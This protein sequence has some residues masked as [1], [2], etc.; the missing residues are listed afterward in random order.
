MN[1]LRA[2]KKACFLLTLLFTAAFCLAAYTCSSAP[3][4]R[5][6][7]PVLPA[8]PTEPEPAPAPKPERNVR[9]GIGE[10]LFNSPVKGFTY[11]I[12]YDLMD[13][14]NVGSYRSW[15]SHT[16]FINYSADVSVQD[17]GRLNDGLIQL[18]NATF[19]T[20][21]KRGV[22]EIIGHGIMY[23]RVASTVSKSERT[24]PVRN[25][26]PGSE[27]IRFLEKTEECY[28][29]LSKA[30]TVID[31]WE[32]G[33]ESNSSTF[34]Q[35]PSGVFTQSE[36][37]AIVTDIMYYANKGIRRGNPA[38]V[39]INP[40]FSPYKGPADGAGLLDIADYL[41][42]M[43][44]NIKSGDFPAGTVKSTDSSDYFGGLAWHPYYYHD[45]A[46]DEDWK[47]YNDAIFRVAENNGD[48]DLKVWF[49]EVGFTYYRDDPDEMAELLENQAGYIT[50]MFALIDDMPYVRTVN[51]FRLFNC[52][53][54][55]GWMLAEEFF[56]LFCEPEGGAGFV[57]NAKAYALQKV[58]GG[59]GDL[60][61]HG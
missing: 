16:A 6:Q 21:K 22:K 54:L 1:N 49:T 36:S 45:R 48:D 15:L 53:Q 35:K 18:Y 55:G 32:I 30:L 38:A 44:D 42:K 24:V 37:A 47:T 33:N 9:Y 14:L 20:L 3:T 13:A 25:T 28:Y 11:Q 56:G 39:V 17:S 12:A 7:T 60:T 31:V 34:M 19:N 61:I 10:E 58:Y 51:F 29:Q 5:T 4:D 46:P 26:A 57:P 59:D 8:E 50:D 41:S 40:G 23:P 52:E 2:F 43:Y 27:Y